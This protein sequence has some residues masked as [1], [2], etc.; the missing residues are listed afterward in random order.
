MTHSQLILKITY[1]VGKEWCIFHIVRFQSITFDKLVWIQIEQKNCWWCDLFRVTQNIGQTRI[2]N[3]QTIA[4]IDTNTESWNN[5]CI[6]WQ[7]FS[8]NCSWSSVIMTTDAGC[9]WRCFINV[10]CVFFPSWIWMQQRRWTRIIQVNIIKR[11]SDS[12]LPSAF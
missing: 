8:R 2:N 11:C 10:L 5:W 4:F 3:P 12:S 6:A 9:C 7:S 1:N